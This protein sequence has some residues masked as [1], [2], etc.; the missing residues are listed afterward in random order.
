MIC[1]HIIMQCDTVRLYNKNIFMNV[2]FTERLHHTSFR[3]TDC[4]YSFGI[5]N[6]RLHSSHALKHTQKTILAVFD[7][8]G[9]RLCHTITML[10]AAV[11]S[12]CIS[13]ILLDNAVII[14]IISVDRHFL[15]V[16]I[17]ILTR[18]EMAFKREYAFTYVL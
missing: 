16:R 10:T 3:I 11:V 6:L 1:D 17:Y 7:E 8:Y 15:P 14:F 18:K 13:V 12:L 4:K 5:C 2:I 9:C